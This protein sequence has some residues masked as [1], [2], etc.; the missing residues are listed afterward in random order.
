MKLTTV[1]GTAIAAFGL[2]ACGSTVVPT[3]RPATPTPTIAPTVARTLTPTAAPTPHAVVTALTTCAGA[4]H[5][6]VDL[7]GFS[8]DVTYT[9]SV[10][11]TVYPDFAPYSGVPF[12]PGGVNPTPPDGTQVWGTQG[13]GF[14]IGASITVT[15]SPDDGYTTTSTIQ[16]PLDCPT[17]KLTVTTACAD[18][19]G[20]PDGYMAF[21][22]GIE[23]MLF[24]IYGPET[25][26]SF[27][28]LAPLETDA[29]GGANDGSI[30]AGSY[31]YA[32]VVPDSGPG[33]ID[34][35]FTVTA[36][37]TSVPGTG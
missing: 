12:G 8:S 22:G 2:A 35:S 24:E 36:C 28:L 21:T 34:G 30:G 32:Y 17:P 7:Y 10:T 33:T 25:K 23:G 13:K 26:G 6:T 11:N 15:I 37:A 16:A 31:E 5:T 3:A 9:V 29:T 20:L 19:G 18:P 4:W 27:P 1:I 14:H